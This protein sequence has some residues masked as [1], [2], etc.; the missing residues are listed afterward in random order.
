MI[1]N[2]KI[3]GEQVN[4]ENLIN[5]LGYNLTDSLSDFVSIH[6]VLRSVCK[7]RVEKLLY[8]Q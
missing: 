1:L 4:F 6:V 8:R 3:V 5:K 2:T 7:I